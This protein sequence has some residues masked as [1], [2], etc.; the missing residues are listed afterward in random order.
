L[1]LAGWLAVYKSWVIVLYCM[2]K[3]QT[4][5]PQGGKTKDKKESKRIDPVY[6]FS[7]RLASIPE[8]FLRRVVLRERRRPGRS[9]LS[10]QRAYAKGEILTGRWTASG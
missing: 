3:V 1:L 6:C 7:L 8:L 4:S 2:Y 9:L 5:L 10:A